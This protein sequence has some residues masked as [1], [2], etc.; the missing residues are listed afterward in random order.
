MISEFHH[1]S[2]LLKPSIEYLCSDQPGRFLDCTLGGGGHTEAILNAHPE[3]L[4][5]GI[6]RDP[7]ALEAAKIRLRSFGSR[8][9]AI[10]GSF[11][12]ILP[13]LQDNS[14]QGVLMDLGVSSPQ[15]D[16]PARGFSFQKDGPLDMRMNPSRGIPASEWLEQ[17]SESELANIIYQYGE[18]PR[19]RRIA[20][21]IIA[22]R[23]FSST[24][25]LADVIRIASR[26]RNS[27]TH[28]ATRTF[29]AI[30]IALNDELGQLRQAL[31]L[32]FDKLHLDG[33]LGVISFHSLED[34]IVKHFFQEYAGEKSEKDQYGNPLS[35][36]RG[37]RIVRKG[38]SG[39]TADTSNPRAR[40][41]RLRILRKLLL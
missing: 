35:P 31:P 26:Y 1:Q 34:R 37:K 27:K 16:Q 9:R 5:I 41:A 10:N 33:H 6:D 20:K 8:F 14:F 39:R 23:P 17:I 15:L 40:S 12:E 25:E 3:N 19:S 29:Q 13:S 32:A 21:A 18:E 11:A 38:I 24:V 4:V 22:Q 30:R 36:V 28:P 7:Q 2:V